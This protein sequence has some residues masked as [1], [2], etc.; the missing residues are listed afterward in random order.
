MNLAAHQQILL[1]LIRSNYETRPEDDV[2]FHRVSRSKDLAEAR[3]NVLLWRVYVLERSCPLTFELLKQRCLL[4]DELDG[5]ISKQ[6]ISPFREFQAPLF[7]ENL[8]GHCDHLVASVSQFELAL[9][10]VREGDTGTYVI[11]WTVDPHNILNALAKRLPIEERPAGARY[12]T[13]V[14]QDYSG[15]FQIHDLT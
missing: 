9:M 12:Q 15:I 6:N 5:F 10:K 2:Y 1:G 3:G 11:D 7:L 8:E 14:S 13:R 4:K